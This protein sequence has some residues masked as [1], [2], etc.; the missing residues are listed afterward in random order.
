[1]QALVCLCNRVEHI[2]PP[3]A[4]RCLSDVRPVPTVA[5]RTP[6]RVSSCPIR[7]QGRGNAR[8]STWVTYANNN[9]PDRPSSLDALEK[10]FTNQKDS[11]ESV[12]DES[13]AS[14]SE[15]EGEVTVNIPSLGGEDDLP[16]RAVFRRC[17]S[18]S[19]SVMAVELEL[20]LGFVM[21]ETAEEEPKDKLYQVFVSEVLPDSNAARGGVKPGD[22]IRAVSACVPIMKYPPG[23]LLLGG[24]GRPGFRQ[25]LVDIL[26]GEVDER[27]DDFNKLL[28][29]LNSHKKAV[30]RVVLVLER[31]VQ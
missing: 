27:P 28:A 5:H 29:A 30:R 10:M 6:A 4:V 14:V 24:V 8:S 31:D 12:A 19:S 25:V 21:E 9:E 3:K 7:L 16:M 11:K 26:C 18:A 1:M 20:P 23:N 15:N 22:V 2:R 17:V 13:E